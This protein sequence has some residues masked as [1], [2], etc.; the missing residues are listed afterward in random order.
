[1]RKGLMTARDERQTGDQHHNRAFHER[2]P[3]LR[4]T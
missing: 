1:M 4:R 3:L 2:S